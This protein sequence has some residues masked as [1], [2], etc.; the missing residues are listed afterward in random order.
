MGGGA[1][2]GR[3]WARVVG[4][5]GGRGLKGVTCFNLIVNNRKVCCRLATYEVMSVSKFTFEIRKCI[6]IDK[7]N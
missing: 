6:L 3:G 5:F 1:R 2:E 7:T 4:F